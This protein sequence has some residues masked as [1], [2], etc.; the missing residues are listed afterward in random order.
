MPCRVQTVKHLFARG[1]TTNIQNAYLPILLGLKW[2]D[3]ATRNIFIPRYGS[4][5]RLRQGIPIIWEGIISNLIL[6]LPM[7]VVALQERRKA[8][9]P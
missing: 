6:Y 5:D 2:I 4:K 9:S 8:L 1:L 7:L 3:M